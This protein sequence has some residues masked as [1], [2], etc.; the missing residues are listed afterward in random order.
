LQLLRGG[1]VADQVLKNRQHVL[2]VLHD[3]FQ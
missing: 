1:V 2:P 3:P